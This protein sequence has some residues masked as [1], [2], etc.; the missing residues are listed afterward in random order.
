MLTS[1]LF[2]Y[3]EYSQGG[4]VGQSVWNVAAGYVL[5]SAVTSDLLLAYLNGVRRVG[6]DSLVR[7]L[8]S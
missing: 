7:P 6:Q 3:L 8:V 5:R 1:A 4:V 2:R